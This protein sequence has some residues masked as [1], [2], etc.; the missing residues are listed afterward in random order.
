[1]KKASQKN[2][3]ASS[4][5]AVQ[6]IAS[7]DLRLS[8]NQTCWPAQ[9]AMETALGEAL[10]AEGFDL[11]RSHPYKEDEKHGFIASQREG[12]EVFRSIDPDAPLI[13]AEAVWQYSHHVL[14]GLTT[15]R[16]PILTVANWSGQWPGLVGMLN[17]NGSLTKAGVRYSTLWSLDFTDTFFK[18]KLRQWLKTG[19]ITHDLSHVQKLEKVK[20]PAQAAKLG[21]Q[22]GEELRSQKAILGI[23]DEGCMGMFNAIIPDHALHA[24][25]V[26]KERLSQSSLFY[27]T[28]QT[29]DDEAHAVLAWLEK[30]G[31]KFHFGKNHATELTREQV[32]LQ[33]KMYVA[34]LRIADDFGCDSIGIQYQQGLKD[35]LPASDLVEG[36]LNNSDRPPVTS[37]DGSHVLYKGE[38][39][40]HF[41]EVDE[42]AGLDGL[43]TCRVHQALGQ[44]VESTLHDVRWGEQYGDDYVWVLLISGAAPPAHFIKG[45]KGADGHRQPA[46]YFPNGGSTLRGVS[47]PGEIVWSRIYVENEALHM[48]IGR[49]GVVELP[50]AETERRWQAT[51][52][53]WPIMHAV[54]YGVSRDQLMAKH[55]ANHIQVAYANDGKAADNCLF[56]K[57]AFA[58]ELGIKVNVCGTR[59]RTKGWG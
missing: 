43:M 7:G 9:H 55:Q 1:M 24:C 37:R 27:E 56:T 13:V 2:S 18:S 21:A 25:G 19:K 40:V 54:T 28:L 23:F 5:P 51:T 11:V 49:G 3:T 4:R 41:N 57:A 15:H 14:A 59:T 35:L 29:P 33:C 44:P 53:Q 38:P 52:P 30:K 48:D 47:K 32:L 39:L 22:L 12:I 50:K 58:R 42:C 6:L 20:V 34:A 26:F 17:L 31:M 8:A 10:A 46:M 45:W 36:T 16:G